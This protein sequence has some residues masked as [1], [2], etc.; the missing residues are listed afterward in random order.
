MVAVPVVG[1][2]VAPAAILG[3]DAPH[4]SHAGKQVELQGKLADRSGMKG[5]EVAAVKGL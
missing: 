5:I 3:V 2:G 4:K 1:R